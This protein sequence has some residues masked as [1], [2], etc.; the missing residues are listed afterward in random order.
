M[1]EG[2]TGEKEPETA[3]RGLRDTVRNAGV[4]WLEREAVGALD[5]LRIEASSKDQ[6]IPRVTVFGDTPSGTSCG[7]RGQRRRKE[8]PPRF[9]TEYRVHES[10]ITTTRR[11]LYCDPYNAPYDGC[12]KGKEKT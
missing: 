11:S 5:A 4:G 9:D 12:E 3:A 1:V 6:E 10:E 7:A 8:E 2:P